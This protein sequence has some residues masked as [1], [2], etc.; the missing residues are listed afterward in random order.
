MSAATAASEDNNNNNN[1]NE[2]QGTD[3]LSKQILEKQSQ[4]LSYMTEASKAS[5]ERT[6]YLA[7]KNSYTIV[8]DDGTRRTVQ[9]KGL[10]NKKNKEIDDLRTAFALTNR[11]DPDKPLKVAG[12]EFTSVGDI[13]FTAFQK[14]AEYCLGLTAEEYD[15]AIAED[16]EELVKEDVWGTRSIILACLVRAVHGLAYFHNPSKSS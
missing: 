1:N 15:N 2:I 9:R 13:V 7:K 11:I 8:F 16:D 5:D 3:E 14:T 6:K 12:Y 10:S 4:E